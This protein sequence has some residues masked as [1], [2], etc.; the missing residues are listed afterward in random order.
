MLFAVGKTTRRGGKKQQVGYFVPILY[1]NPSCL[2]AHIS[3]FLP[4]IAFVSGRGDWLKKGTW[5]G[6]LDF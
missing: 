1:I 5:P 2:D 3:F 4:Q 6:F